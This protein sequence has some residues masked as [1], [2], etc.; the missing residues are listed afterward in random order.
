[1]RC[2]FLLLPYASLFADIPTS[3][4]DLYLLLITKARVLLVHSSP[5]LLRYLFFSPLLQAFFR[6]PTFPFVSG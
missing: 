3:M 2:D 6:Y 1:M 4:G 5:F